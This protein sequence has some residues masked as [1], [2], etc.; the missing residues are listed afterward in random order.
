M[1]ACVER[2]VTAGEI[3]ARQGSTVR[4]S[5]GRQASRMDSKEPN[6]DRWLKMAITAR[7]W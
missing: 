5:M 4:H 1:M 2:L 7:R 3:G 6:P